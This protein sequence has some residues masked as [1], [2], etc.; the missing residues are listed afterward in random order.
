MQLLCAWTLCVTVAVCC[1]GSGISFARRACAEFIVREP[2]AKSRSAPQ[3]V[4][5]AQFGRR[6]SRAQQLHSRRTL[7]QLAPLSLFLSCS[8]TPTQP[9]IVCHNGNQHSRLRDC[10]RYQ[11]ATGCLHRSRLFSI[12]NRPPTNLRARQPIKWEEQ[13][14]RGSASVDS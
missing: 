9:H 8:H 2:A 12:P 11:Q 3:S 13:C 6:P 7:S 10:F 1:C 5:L 14:T 4:S